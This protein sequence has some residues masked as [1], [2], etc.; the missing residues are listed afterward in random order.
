MNNSIFFLRH[1][2]TIID[3]D[4]PVEKWEI[5]KKGKEKMSKIVGSGIFDEIDIVVSS[6]EKKAIQT[7]TFVA[8]RL[9]KEI[10]TYSDYN[11]LRREGGYI[12]SKSEY[13]KQ[14]RLIFEEGSSE[15]KEWE[16]ARNALDR[17]IKVTD[18]IDN[19]YSNMKILVVSHGIILSLYFGH[20][21]NVNKD[22]YFKRW[23]KMEFCGW[24][25]IKN[26]K[27]VKDIIN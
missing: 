5:A 13:E 7:A 12:T 16:I 11:E 27:V 10:I 1:A 19:Q 25:I 22:E 2:I 14:V 6:K 8:E 15:I 4:T 17:I 23:K 20:L 3:E 9:G 18:L 26:K 21:L 24:G